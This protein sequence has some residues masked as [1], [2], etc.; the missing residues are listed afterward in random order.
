MELEMYKTLSLIRIRIVPSRMRILSI[1][2]LVALILFSLPLA[3]AQAADGDL[4]LT[5]GNGG[6]VVTNFD[7]I[8]QASAVGVQPDGKIVA[9]GASTYR[10]NENNR[11]AIARYNSNGTPDN[12]FGLAGRVTTDIGGS[13]D[14]YAFAFQ[15]NGQNLYPRRLL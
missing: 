8:D 9:V 4:D 1:T 11:F 12:S 13:A 15:P 14:A 7:A 10:P 5:F 3:A 2:V 6:R